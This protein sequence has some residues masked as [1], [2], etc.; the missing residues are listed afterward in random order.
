MRETRM[1]VREIPGVFWLLNV[2]AP[3]ISGSDMLG[4][5]N[6]A[7]YRERAK[8]WREEAETLP[9]GKERDA[10]IGL[11][12]GYANLAALIEKANNG[13]GRPGGD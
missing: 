6:P 7:T 9:P 3:Y 13:C 2:K 5:W 11:A 12:E 10:C 8:K 1:K 4:T